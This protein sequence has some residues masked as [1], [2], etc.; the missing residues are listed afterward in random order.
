[1]DAMPNSG[2]Y[3]DI[4]LFSTKERLLPNDGADYS[5]AHEAAVIWLKFAAAFV[6]QL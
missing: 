5:T 3:V 6:H 2:K 1:M 4:H